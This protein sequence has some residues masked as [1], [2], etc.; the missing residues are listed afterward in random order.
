[1]NFEFDT[2]KSAPNKI[3]HGIDFTKAQALWRDPFYVEIPAKVSD[4]ARFLVVG[5]INGVYWSGVITY[6]GEKI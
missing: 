1:M 6:R 3:K 5:K 2:K 4:E